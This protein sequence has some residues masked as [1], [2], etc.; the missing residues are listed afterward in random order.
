[1]LPRIGGLSGSKK[2]QCFQEVGDSVLPRRGD[3]VLPR[4]GE[5]SGSK[6]RGTRWFQ[7]YRN[8]AVPRPGGPGG[9]KTRGLSGFRIGGF[10]GPK[11]RGYSAVPGKGGSQWFQE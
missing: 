7:K 4:S 6:N 11:N 9:S 8:L 5:L 2:Y 3:S 1:M 10:N